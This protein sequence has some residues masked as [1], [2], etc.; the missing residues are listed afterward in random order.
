MCASC[1]LGCSMYIW[2]KEVNMGM[3]RRGMRFREDGREWRLSR[4]LYADDLVLRMV[5]GG[6]L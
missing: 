5:K 4:L 6:V 1:S 2:V 3:G